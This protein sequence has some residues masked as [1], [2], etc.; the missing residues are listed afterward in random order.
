MQFAF[1]R[2]RIFKQVYKEAEKDLNHDVPEVR[3]RGMMELS[4][5][6]VA[7][8]RSLSPREKIRKPVRRRER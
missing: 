2:P 8:P 1:I 3:I 6:R 7:C 5:V 4:K